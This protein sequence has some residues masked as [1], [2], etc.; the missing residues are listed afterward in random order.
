MGDGEVYEEWIEGPTYNYNGWL[1]RTPSEEKPDLNRPGED[2]QTIAQ[3]I[4]RLS[5]G[6]VPGSIHAFEKERL[7]MKEKGIKEA[8]FIADWSEALFLQSFH[9]R[10]INLERDDEGEKDK[11]A[12]SKADYPYE[13]RKRTVVFG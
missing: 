11:A 12:V 6:I 10:A 5:R 8:D 4:Y 7:E 1:G 9:R 3:Q 2:G 13:T